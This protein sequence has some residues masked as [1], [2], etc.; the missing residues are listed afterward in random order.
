MSTSAY[1]PGMTANLLPSKRE[2]IEM[3]SDFQSNGLKW[4][5]IFFYPNTYFK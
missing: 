4:I 5:E 3:D 1:E 2:W